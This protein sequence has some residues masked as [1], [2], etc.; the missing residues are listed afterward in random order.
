MSV[1]AISRSEPALTD[2]LVLNAM[3]ATRTLTKGGLL[4]VIGIMGEDI[5][6]RDRAGRHWLCRMR[7]MT[8]LPSD[9]RAGLAGN[10]LEPVFGPQLPWQHFE[11]RT[12]DGKR[13]WEIVEAARQ[14]AAA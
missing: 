4:N 5:A 13:L 3:E 6:V 8:D 7:P 11:A 12:A 1:P 14:E 10:W 2:V 9:A